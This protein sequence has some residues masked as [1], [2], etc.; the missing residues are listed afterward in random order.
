MLKKIPF[1]RCDDVVSGEVS[2]LTSCRFVAALYVAVFHLYD[3]SVLSKVKENHFLSNGNLAVDFFF[4][5]SG[6]IL[7][8]NYSAAFREKRFDY[9]AFVIKRIAR[10]YPVH[11]ITLLLIIP[12][13]ILAN[14]Q[15][16]VAKTDLPADELLYNLLLV[17]AW[18]GRDVLS[19]NVPSWSISAEFF[20]YLLFPFF[21]Y[22]AGCM[23][24]IFSV[25]AW[26]SIFVFFYIFMILNGFSIDLFSPA[27]AL[28]RVTMNFGLGVAVY[29]F[30]S[31]YKFTGDVK[32]ALLICC[33][34]MACALS[35]KGAELALPMIYSF[36][37]LLLY[38]AYRSGE[39][40]FIDGPIW[41]YLGRISYS[42]YMVHFL[43]LV[44]VAGIFVPQLLMA[45]EA[46]FSTFWVVL[47][48]CGILALFF[49]AAMAAY[50][51]IEVPARKYIV[52]KMIK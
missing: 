3:F 8:F 36:F 6:F 45:N 4:I 39:R 28:C 27:F 52:R 51:F 14:M 44:G 22:V 1:I 7:A 40:V 30:I 42:F 11:F 25:I 37:I 20:V 23:K 43:V 50:H 31:Q 32:R 38:D 21:I 49:P 5:L 17:H 19:Y 34:L 35:T 9:R 10:I 15:H 2:S 47:N 26:G 12:L 46:E 18:W 29:F 24:P 16:D 41:Q 33:I 48:L 13:L